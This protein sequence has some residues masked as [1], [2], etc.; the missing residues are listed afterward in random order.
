MRI[1]AFA[2]QREL[3]LPETTSSGRSE[4]WQAFGNPNNGLCPF[5]LTRHAAF[6]DGS[7]AFITKNQTMAAIPTAPAFTSGDAVNCV[8]WIMEF[9]KPPNINAVKQETT[10]FMRLLIGRRANFLRELVNLGYHAGDLLQRTAQ[11]AAE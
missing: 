3:C 7:S 2:A 4:N 11:V 1:P 5:P 6:R 8:D 9:V 10:L